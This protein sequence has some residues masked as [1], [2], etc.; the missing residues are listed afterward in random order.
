MGR[1]RKIPSGDRQ[2]PDGLFARA[3]H[4]PGVTRQ[5]CTA[6]EVVV[7]D[8]GPACTAI[9]VVV[10]DAGPACTAI[11]V[12]VFDAGP[13]CTAI[14]VVVFDAGPA[15]TAIEVVV[16]D[17][18]PACTAID[19]VVLCDRTEV[20]V[21]P[22]APAVAGITQNIA[23][24]P[25]ANSAINSR[26]ITFSLIPPYFR[27]SLRTGS[28]PPGCPGANRDAAP[29][30]AA[31]GSRAPDRRRREPTRDHRRT[32]ENVLTHRP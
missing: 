19:V 32:P 8:A 16:F 28:T 11:D 27:H 7:L 18:G 14:E 24:A 25:M 6:I 17:A 10:F 20:T 5:P 21:L 12:V 1:L 31:V 26:L 23:S 30:P 3:S 9:D 15:C 2:G 4:R 22:D 13:A 29:A